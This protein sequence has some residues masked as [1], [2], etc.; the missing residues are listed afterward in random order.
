MG[1][2]RI[3]DLNDTINGLLQEKRRWERRIVELGGPNHVCCIPFFFSLLPLALTG[4]VQQGGSTAVY[5]SK[6]NVIGGG[7]SAREYKYFGA[8]RDL[9]GVRQVLAEREKE[10]KERVRQRQR[11]RQRG[12][13][14]KRDEEGGARTVRQLTPEYYGYAG[15]DDDDDFET[16]LREAEDQCEAAA[17]EAA[18]REWDAAHAEAHGSTDE[19]CW[20]DDGYDERLLR[21]LEFVERV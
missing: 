3:R 21:A 17:V 5:D 18:Q 8:A 11:Q 1:E 10:A 4:D 14:Q 19:E 20:D 6:G 16:A 9:P 12:S 15:P 2:Q 7:G 13:S